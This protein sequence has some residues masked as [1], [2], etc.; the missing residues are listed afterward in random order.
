MTQNLADYYSYNPK[1][2]EVTLSGYIADACKTP[3]VYS[4]INKLTSNPCFC[5]YNLNYS[6]SGDVWFCTDSTDP[7]IPKD[8]KVKLLLLGVPYV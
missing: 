1:T 2:G 7:R 8:F 6:T 4:T 3:F 5:I